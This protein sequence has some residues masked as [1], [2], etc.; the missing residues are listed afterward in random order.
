MTTQ[1]R[2]RSRLRRLTRVFG[3]QF[4]PEM[5]GLR[6]LPFTG[7]FGIVVAVEVVRGTIPHPRS[8]VVAVSIVIVVQL[9]ALFGAWE[10]WPHWWQYALPLAQ[11][12]A[13]GGL[14]YGSGEAASYFSSMLFLPVINLA[15]QPGYLGLALGTAGAGVVTM[16]PAFLSVRPDVSPSAPTRAIVVTTCAFLVGTGASAVTQRLREQAATLE[17]LRRQQVATMHSLEGSR[18]RLQALSARL[19]QSRDLLASVVEAATEQLIVGTD[20]VGTIMINSPGARVLL[21]GTDAVLTGSSVTDFFDP[22]GLRGA[23]AARGLGSTAVDLLQGLVGEAGVGRPE[24]REWTLVRLDGSSLPVEVTV[25]RRSL[26][27]DAEA[28]GYLFVATDLTQRKEAERLQDEFIGLV[29]HE[30]RTPLASIMGYVELLRSDE[31]ALTVA[32]NHSLDVVER[33]AQRLLRLVEDLLLSVQVV[34]GTFALDA[35]PL[36]AT[37]TVRRSVANL[38]PTADTAGVT[39]TVDAPEGVSLVT[40]PERLGQVVENLVANAVKFSAR[41]GTVRVSVHA[42][43]AGDGGR[44]AELVVADD[45]AGMTADE[46]ERVTKR[47]FRTR[48][49]QQQRVRG[50]G[51]GLSIVDAIVT[52][53][54]GTMAIRSTPREGTTVTVDLPDAR[55]APAVSADPDPQATLPPST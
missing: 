41:G 12:A 44:G 7:V 21:G 33:N 42:T 43:A 2:P 14:A 36:D 18:D 31:G 45:G 37:E 4:D 1:A 53:H 25:T 32:Q 8:T 23:A 22:E 28:D 35:R 47:F 49:A 48:T 30:L 38:M 13:L 54:G 9:V 3:S 27:D 50:L 6:E 20:E 15:L 5:V 55:E 17:S 39:V 29:S 24:H 11:I 26:L 19:E 34:A 40:D 16:L 46:L 10:R 51:L 52:A